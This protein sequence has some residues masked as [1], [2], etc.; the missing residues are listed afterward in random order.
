MLHA[1]YGRTFVLRRAL[2]AP[3]PIFLLL[4]FA[5]SRSR[6]GARLLM[7]CVAKLQKKVL[8]VPPK[9]EDSNPESV[10]AGRIVSRVAQ[11]E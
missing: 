2:L 8:G 9:R 7:K 10:V 4:Q 1:N 6:D 5:I 3:G 11:E